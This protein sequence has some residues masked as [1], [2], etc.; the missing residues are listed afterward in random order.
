MRWSH[1][2]G[3]GLHCLEVSESKW[4]HTRLNANQLVDYLNSFRIGTAI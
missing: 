3:A 4:S 1:L 2:R